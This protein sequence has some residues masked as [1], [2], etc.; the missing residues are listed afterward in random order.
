MWKEFLLVF[1]P[2]FVAV[3]AIGVLPIFISLTQGYGKREKNR[4]IIQSIFTALCLAI[5]FLF[6]GKAVFRFLNITIGDF[7]VAGGILLFCI[8]ILDIVNPT[9]QRRIPTQEIAS[10]PLGTPL[11]VGPAV[12][13]T[14]LIMLQ[15]H[16]LVLTLGAV[17]ANVLLGA[18][19]FSLSGVIIKTIG[20]SGTRALSKIAALFL[21]AIAVMMVRKG[22]IF[23]L[24]LRV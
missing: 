6:L 5:A 4:I 21:S 9:K 2:L 20:E 19:I 15:Q 14:S 8:A 18:L 17:L 7:L 24:A 13:T 12:L 1:I 23:L 10:V 16:G 11:I 22:I 3:D